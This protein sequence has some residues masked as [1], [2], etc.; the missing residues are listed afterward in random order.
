M[1][2]LDILVVYATPTDFNSIKEGVVIPNVVIG[3]SAGAE[4]SLP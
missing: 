1:C 2:G 3:L 4:S